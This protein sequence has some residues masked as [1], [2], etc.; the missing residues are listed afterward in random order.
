MLDTIRRTPWPG[1]ALV[2]LISVSLIACGSSGPTP[3]PTPT[4]VPTPQP[5]TVAM[6]S[7]ADLSDPWATPFLSR[8]VSGPIWKEGGCDDIVIEG[9]TFKDL[10]PD[11][12][13]IHL[14]GCNN[15][16]IRANDFAR[17]AQAITVE[18]S[19]NVRIEWN[20]YLDIIGPHARVPGLNRAN[21]AQLDKV[22][23]GFI[24][25]NKGKGGDTE[26]IVSLFRTGGT[27]E[28][29]FVVEYNHFQG[30]DWVSRSGSGIA[31]GDS[32]SSHSVA[33]YNILL[34]PGQ[35]GIFIAGGTD[36]QIIGNTIYGEQRP[37]SNVGIYVWNQS[38]D[39]CSANEVRDNKVSWA[40]EDGAA[41]PAWD[42]GNCGTTDGWDDNEWHAELDPSTMEVEL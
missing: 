33:R 23:G 28:A 24:S 2:L 26:D 16:T 36:H 17:V 15:V 14:K 7:G 37:K 3:S 20:R 30:V 1:T 18:E 39:P 25:H 34:N 29:P 13:A 5:S 12:E 19:K 11:V 27:H 21:F 31:L 8:P 22:T 9:L 41:N 42:A 4:P 6:P 40:R 10:G 32:T 35:A 38:K